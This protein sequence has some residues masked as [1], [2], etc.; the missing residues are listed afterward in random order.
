MRGVGLC[1]EF[2]IDDVGFAAQFTFPSLGKR[3]L[4]RRSVTAWEGIPDAASEHHDRSIRGGGLRFA[5]GLCRCLADE[6]K[7]TGE[8]EGDK[9]AVP[10]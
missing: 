10:R 3:R 4:R 1:G 6:Q 2:L 9:E 7:C 8:A 5:S